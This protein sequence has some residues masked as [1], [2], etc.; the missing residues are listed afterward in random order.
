MKKE[1]VYLQF[2][3]Y[4]G[5]PVQAK[6]EI[7]YEIRLQARLNLDAICFNYNR[8]KLEEAINKA[9]ETDD[10]KA[11]KNLSEEYKQYIWE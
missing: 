7:P 10:I 5:K 2:F 4:S 11:F 8:V 6:K 9:L 1:K 3:R